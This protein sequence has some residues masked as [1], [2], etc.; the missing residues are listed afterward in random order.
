MFCSPFMVLLTFCFVILTNKSMQELCEGLW[1]S[2]IISKV[3]WRNEALVCKSDIKV[4][5]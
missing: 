4:N 5:E 1:K 2:A 3:H